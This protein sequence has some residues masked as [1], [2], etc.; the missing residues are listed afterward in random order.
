MY[1]V[2]PCWYRCIRAHTRTH[3]NSLPN[4]NHLTN[5]SNHPPTI[6]Q[7]TNQTNPTNRPQPQPTNR[8]PSIHPP[9]QQT[10]P[11]PQKKKTTGSGDP[12]GGAGPPQRRRRRR[13]AAL[14]PPPPGGGR[15]RGGRRAHGVLSRKTRRRMGWVTGWG[16]GVGREGAAVCDDGQ[17]GGGPC[18]CMAELRMCILYN[19]MW[20]LIVS[21]WLVCM[22]QD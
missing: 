20:G 5:E 22:N 4:L 8:P 13:R 15:G 12:G 9:T 6:H 14:R 11:P 19:G 10:N 21:I 17:G 2:I 16:C 18:C 7:P 3:Y 1:V